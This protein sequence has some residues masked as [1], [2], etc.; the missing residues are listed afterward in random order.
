MIWVE[1]MSLSA[2]YKDV[3]F[4]ILSVLA[5]KILRPVLF[6]ISIKFLWFD[7][8]VDIAFN[9]GTDWD[10]IWFLDGTNFFKLWK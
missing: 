9:F 8:S 5:V 1:E 6:C 3:F 7:L 4:K 2:T 10:L